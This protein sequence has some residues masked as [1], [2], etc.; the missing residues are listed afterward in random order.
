MLLLSIYIYCFIRAAI[1]VLKFTYNFSVYFCGCGL[2]C[3]RTPFEWPYL[4]RAC[5]VVAR[6]YSCI[7]KMCAVELSAQYVVVESL[8]LSTERESVV[9][10]YL[11]NDYPSLIAYDG[12]DPHTH[13]PS[14]TVVRMN[15]FHNY[16]IVCA[17]C[18]FT[19]WTSTDKLIYYV[20][21]IWKC[22][23][24]VHLRFENPYRNIDKA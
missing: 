9:C 3:A 4:H 2:S 1:I 21:Y 10:Q 12:D 24:L 20:K 11:P 13:T 14:H 6:K 19:T 22:V 7:T 17:R 5:S 18:V 8:L 23:A 16:I 15:A